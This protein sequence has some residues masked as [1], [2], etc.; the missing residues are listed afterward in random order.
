MTE[1]APAGLRRTAL[2]GVVFA[3]LAGAVLSGCGSDPDAGTNGVGKLSASDIQNKTRAAARAARTVR[4]SGSLAGKGGTYKLDMRLKDGGG[5][6]SVTSKSAT[7]HLL[8]IDDELFLKAGADFWGSEGEAKEGDSSEAADKLDGKYV[9]VPQGDPAYEQ[10][11]GF[12][13]MDSLLDSLATLHG[14]LERGD[15]RD[16]SGVKSIEINGD[17]GGGGTLDVS[18]EGKPYPLLLTR[19]GDAG[20]LTFTD[21]D[22]P[23]SLKQPPKDDT[24]DYGK[25]LPSS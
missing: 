14:A 12:T 13:D 17:K 10:L 19:A 9:R 24:V 23:L 16:V 20:S 18:L 2:L 22:K 8:R 11:S 4:L 15:H 1:I 7:F 6:G 3:G 21:W 25:N 5:A